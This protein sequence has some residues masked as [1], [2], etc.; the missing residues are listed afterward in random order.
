VALN[1]ALCTPVQ[2]ASGLPFETLLA[3]CASCH[4]KDRSTPLVPGWGRIDGQNREYLVYALK[5]YRGNGRRGMNAGLMMPFAMTLS[6]RE[7]ERLA[8]HYSN[9]RYLV[10]STVARS[11]RSRATLSGR[12]RPES[13]VAAATFPG[14]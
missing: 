7:I 3:V 6:D 4:G 8:A 12:S 11:M 2:G 13:R 9:V 14:P 5:L 10:E 1:L